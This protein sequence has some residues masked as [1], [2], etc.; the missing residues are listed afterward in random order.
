MSRSMIQQRNRAYT[1]NS[2]VS[3]KDPQS[4]VDKQAGFAVSTA[5][6]ARS[7]ADDPQ[8]SL[9]ES[10]PDHGTER[11]AYRG[12][13]DSLA[14]RRAYHDPALHAFKRPESHFAGALFDLL[15]RERFESLGANLYDGVRR[16]LDARGSDMAGVADELCRLSRHWFRGNERDI[17][18]AE[19]SDGAFVCAETM[20][21]LRQL[22]DNQEAFAE[23]S[24]S[25]L[26]RLLAMDTSF[27]V[28]PDVSATTDAMTDSDASDVE[29]DQPIEDEYLADEDEASSTRAR[30]D[31][32]LPE[33]GIG[34]TVET[35]ELPDAAQD[36]A[37][38]SG[39]DPLL[40]QSGIGAAYTAFTTRFDEIVTADSLASEASLD[41]WRAELDEHLTRQGR[42]VRRLAT[43]LQRVL[44]AR[45]RRQWQF[46]MP[47][48]V[49]DTARLS[50]LVTDPL[51][52]L[53]FK[54]DKES[55]FKDTTVTLM[56]DNS[57][58]MLGRP[59]MIAAACAD[60]LAQTLER[61]GV[62][63]EIL[64][65]TTVELHGG[66]STAAWEDAGRP[67]APGRLNDLRHIIYK[68]ADMPYRN[69]RRNLGLMLDKDVL[70]QN[71]DGESLLWAYERLRRRPEERKILMV[72]SDGAP[73]DTSTL[74]A[75][76]GDF[77][78]RHL[79]SVVRDIES[80]RHVE[81]MA[82]GIGHDVSRFYRE[83][84]SVFDARQLG[85]AMLTQL[86]SLFRRAT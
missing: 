51:L 79:D 44:L 13:A 1:H 26:E 80:A 35:D 53:T 66:Q 30:E 6:C 19:L 43:R 57:R 63:V 65:F 27:D 40:V 54:T 73:V 17:D 75:N 5:A 46:D 25:L 69:A 84:M 70:K 61:C 22:L 72:I 42:L 41:Q 11:A 34:E 45:Q 9:S 8:F 12:Q 37:P 28:D 20:P 32:V 21:A 77:L 39:S 2:P 3:G 62:S 55:P 36:E 4:D 38:G 64:G 15:E 67:D 85:S 48:G 76:H 24:V 74:A 58:S 81:L 18:R 14:L 71:I 52:P 50:R 86:E 59:I 68:S 29:A 16:N 31:E 7:L 60:V 49:L 33:A 83:S 82:I 56:L 23:L 78:V 10:A 47:E